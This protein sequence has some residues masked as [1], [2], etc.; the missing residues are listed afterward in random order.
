MSWQEY[1]E[2]IREVEEREM[3]AAYDRYLSMEMEEQ[4]RIYDEY[5]Y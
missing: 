1:D 3:E 2:F 5:G 4:D